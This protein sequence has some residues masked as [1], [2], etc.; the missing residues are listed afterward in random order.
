MVSSGA[1]NDNMAIALVASRTGWQAG[2]APRLLVVDQ[3][4]VQPELV[5]HGVEGEDE[6]EMPD[7]L[8]VSPDSVTEDVLDIGAGVVVQHPGELPAQN[9]DLRD[10]PVAA[11]VLRP[12]DLDHLP[13]SVDRVR[14]GGVGADRAPC[15]V[16]SLPGDHVLGHPAR[17]HRLP[18]RTQPGRLLHDGHLSSP[19]AHPVGQRRTCNARPR[20]QHQRT[21]PDTALAR[22]NRRGGWRDYP[23]G[24][25]E[26]SMGN[27]RRRGRD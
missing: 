5:G 7:E 12:V 11:V 22:R 15:G 19:S 10:I 20:H 8:L 24:R 27:H 18:A 3:P 21:A 2:G 25:G 9:L 6:A 14:T 4:A 17:V 23:D 26:G 1:G 16:E 13:I